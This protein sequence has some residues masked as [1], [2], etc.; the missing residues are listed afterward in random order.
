MKN[1]CDGP[2]KDFRWR[3]IWSF[4]CSISMSFASF[5]ASAATHRP[6]T[7]VFLFL[8]RF[9]FDSQSNDFSACLEYRNYFIYIHF[10]S[11]TVYTFQERGT[12]DKTMKIKV[13]RTPFLG[14]VTLFIDI[15]QKLVLEFIFSTT[16]L[17]NQSTKCIFLN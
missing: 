7:C 1:N 6:E 11:F 16:H 14:Y 12:Y 10:N 13:A 17:L 15:R 2:G 8:N 3:F 9:G 4:F 5:L